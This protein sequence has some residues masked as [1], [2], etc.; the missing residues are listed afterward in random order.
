[1]GETGPETENRK[2]RVGRSVFLNHDLGSLDHRR[3]G[4]FFL[5]LQFISAAPGDGALNQIVPHAHNHMRHDV[6]QL[7]LFDTSTEFVTS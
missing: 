6:A 4:V 2:R 7:N 5:Q 3:H 1:M